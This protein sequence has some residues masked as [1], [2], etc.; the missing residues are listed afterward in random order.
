M[1]L[2]DAELIC[3]YH[4]GLPGT[5]GNSAR[6][7]IL[8]IIGKRTHSHKEN[9][10]RKTHDI[11]YQ[12]GR[13]L[14]SPGW[15]F[16]FLKGHCAT[17]LFKSSEN[18]TDGFILQVNYKGCEIMLFVGMRTGWQSW[19]S[20]MYFIKGQRRTHRRSQVRNKTRNQSKTGNK[21]N[22]AQAN[23]KSKYLLKTLE[24]STMNTPGSNSG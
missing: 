5:L 22:W 14:W 3:S 8:N 13:Q 21:S 9:T 6:P 17:Y 24:E 16:C 12:E 15:H 7:N 19:I 1:L 10:T 11:W 23:P 20:S 2:I 18:V 4:T